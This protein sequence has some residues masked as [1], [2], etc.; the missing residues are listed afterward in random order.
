M[1]IFIGLDDTDNKDSRGTGHL[2]RVIAK[3]L[4]THYEVEGVTR[5]QLLFDPRVPYTAKNSCAAVILYCQEKPDL[6]DLFESVRAMM[7]SDFQPGSDPGLCVAAEVPESVIAFG[8]KAQTDL[9]SQ[10]EAREIAI[11]HR[12]QLEGLGGTQDGVIGALA[13]VGLASSGDDGRYVQVGSMRELSGLQKVDAVLSAGA[14]AIKTLDGDV[15]TEELILTDK[16]RPARRNKQAV[17][18]VKW[19]EDHWQPVKLD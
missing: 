17:V 5:H 1:N 11:K 14:S 16:L 9:V 15:V 7:L 6:K 13:A 8:R 3:N 19:Y 2:A 12:L 18:F 10:I 4:A